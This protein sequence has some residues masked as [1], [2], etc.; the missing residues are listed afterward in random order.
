VIELL[1]GAPGSGKTT[2]A[3]AMRIAIEALRKVTIDGTEVTRRVLCAG[4]RGL[5]IEHEP[6]PHQLTGDA[7]KPSVVAHWN[8]WKV[9]RDDHGKLHESDEPEHERLPGE[10]P[11]EDCPKI[12]Q[13][14]WLWCKPGDQIAVDEA[15]FLAPRMAIGRKPPVWVQKLEVHR[16][17]GVDFLFVT[18]HPQLVDVVIRKL[19]GLHRHIRPF[20]GL[21]LCLVFSWDHAS[22]PE[23]YKLSN[24]SWFVRWPKYYRLF[25]STVAVIKPPATGRVILYAIPV[26][27]G[28][29][30]FFGGRFFDRLAPGAAIAA[31]AAALAPGASHLEQLQDESKRIAGCWSVD[32]D[33]RCMYATGERVH[34]VPRDVCMVSSVGWDGAVKWQARAAPV[35]PLSAYGA[36]EGAEV[37]PEPSNAPKPAKRPASAVPGASS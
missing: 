21:P 26:L 12:V 18:Q 10:P 7:P 32:A 9:E 31:P 37:P 23:R 14:W 2:F 27:L 19:V 20:F 30:I 13:T 36:K 24:K 35:Q 11:R 5:V 4:F 22:D 16:H 25:H 1:T 28:G 6:L 33:C 15:Q 3:V 34:N 8:A 17:Y 29:A